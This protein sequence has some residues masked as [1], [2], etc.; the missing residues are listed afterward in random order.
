MNI[1]YIYIYHY[2]YP[3]V[4]PLS[5]RVY[6]YIYIIMYVLMWIYD[7]PIA[8]CF[9]MEHASYKW[10]IWGYPAFYPRTWKFMDHAAILFDDS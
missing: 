5:Y 3:Y 7:I 10:M 9:I 8:G 6:I 1:V 4:Y 2:V